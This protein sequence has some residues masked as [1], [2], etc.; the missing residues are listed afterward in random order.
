MNDCILFFKVDK[1]TPQK[2]YNYKHRWKSVLNVL[3]TC[4][5]DILFPEIQPTIDTDDR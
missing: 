2:T 4:N 5:K 3:N 1:S